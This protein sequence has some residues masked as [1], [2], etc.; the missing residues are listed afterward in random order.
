MSAIVV[1]FA[2]GDKVA[3]FQA[4]VVECRSMRETV[5]WNR[6]AR[7]LLLGALVLGASLPK[8]HAQN[9]RL[10]LAFYYAWFDQATWSSGQT[11]D[12]PAQPYDSRDRATIQ[13]HV[14][15]AKSAGIDAF[16]QSWYGPAGGVN[17]MTESNFATL[18]D[19][20]A[21]SGF[22]AAV[23]F[24]VTSPFFGT[25]GDVQGALVTLLSGHVRHPA[26]LRVNGKPVVFFWRQQRFSVDDWTAIRN[27]VDPNRSSI[28]IAEGTDPSYLRVF[29]G[30]HWYS[31][32]WSADPVSSLVNYAARVRKMAQD[33]GGFRY[34][35]SP[36]MPGY[37]DTRL[38]GA[39]G[40][41]RPRD[42]GNYFR[43]TFAGANQ[44]GA[45]WVVVTSFNEWPEGSQIEPSVAYGNTYL[46][47]TRELATA[48]RGGTIAPAAVPSTSSTPSASPPTVT[49]Q[50]P[51]TPVEMVAQSILAA[52][53][54]MPVASMLA[55]ATATLT[56]TPL[57]APTG[58][59]TPVPTAT[60]PPTAW[61]NSQPADTSLPTETSAPTAGVVDISVGTWLTL[62]GAA[63]VLG[64]ALGA[65]TGRRRVRH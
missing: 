28:W 30:I 16:V 60:V 39:G 27:Q 22:R 61:V 55:L 13:R 10:V 57:P 44:S 21:Q 15:Q 1:A 46:N 32:A 54:V 26:Y 62:G 12:Q 8:A 56:P 65:V 42:N 5:N 7:V 2:F 51:P 58:T 29:D 45:D 37:D 43:A 52:P 63:L 48:Y 17:N 64:V 23:D 50:A 6:W 36:A 18:L 24:E 53:S 47:L 31:V 33:L 3:V 25:S 9:E 35:V 19:V 34:W 38:R 11:A 40:L 41:V 4:T 49:P 59:S 20:S 14:A